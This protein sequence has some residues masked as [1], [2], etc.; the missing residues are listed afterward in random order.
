MFYVIMQQQ[1][2][3]AQKKLLDQQEIMIKQMKNDLMNNGPNNIKSKEYLSKHKYVE[4]N[5]HNINGL[6]LVT[7]LS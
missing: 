7:L 3:D 6:I 2:I 4:N 5:I 1:T